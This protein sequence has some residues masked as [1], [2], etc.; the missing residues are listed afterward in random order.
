MR[1][2]TKQR[3]ER[4]IFLQ[5]L[6][7]VGAAAASILVMAGVFAYISADASVQNV[8]VPATITSVGLIPG[9]NV[10]RGLLVGVRL[11]DGRLVNVLVNQITDPQVGQKVEITE[12]QHSTGRRNYSWK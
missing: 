2:E 3:L 7:W 4:A 6:K 8:R 5:R 10:Q 1:A 12:H 11:T 9:K